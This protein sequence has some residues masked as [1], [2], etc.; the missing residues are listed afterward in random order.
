MTN[1]AIIG[2]GLSGLTTANLLKDYADITL[3]EKAKG[4][5][6]RISTRRAEPYFFDHGAQY[7]KVRTDEFKAFI[8]PM[9][10]K[11]IIER[12]DA[13][14]VEFE[15]RKI[16]QKRQWNEEY[17]HYVGVPGMNT[18][19]KYLS[20]DLSIKLNTR[21][22]SIKKELEKWH[23]EDD[24]GNNLGQYDWV[25]LAVPAEQTRD[26]LTSSSLC[27]P[28][29]SK[30]RMQSCFSVML[31]FE[32]ALPL[33]F[34]AA[35][36]RGED[37]SWISINSSKPGRN[38][39]F[40]LLVHSTNQWADKHLEDDQEQLMKYLCKQTC[41]IIGLDINKAAHKAI[42]RWRYANIEKQSGESHFLD[43]SQNF[44]ICG[45]WFIQGRVEAAFSSGFELANTL[46]KVL[47]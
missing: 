46:M 13:R 20:E 36:V 11:G 32:Q 15:N 4:V 34:D 26:L 7:F 1:I 43:S 29:M 9:I 47:K 42:H 6:G 14:F 30:I 18:I 21:V 5:G 24:Q 22:Q 39:A 16:I 44:A 41:E 25:I 35:L 8:N 19:A 27:Y 31:G 17:P 40:S 38:K 2:A 37:I 45:D 23:L 33:E 28:N 10:K 3:F 12:W